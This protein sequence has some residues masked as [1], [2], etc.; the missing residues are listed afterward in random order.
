MPN[1]EHQ[2]DLDKV[3]ANL[4]ASSASKHPTQASSV[5]NISK[6]QCQEQ[7]TKELPYYTPPIVATYRQWELQDPD[8]QY[9]SPV[10]LFLLFFQPIIDLLVY[11]TILQLD[12]VLH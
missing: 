2:Q 3:V 1:F 4:D 5:L 12:A 10:A 8:Y 9:L 6:A 7:I 11:H